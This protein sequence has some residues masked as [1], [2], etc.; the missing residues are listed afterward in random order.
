MSG[1]L[2]RSALDQLIESVADFRVV[3]VNGPRQAGKTTLLSMYQDRHQGQYRSLDDAEQ[4]SAALADPV[5]YVESQVRPL[6]IDEVQRGGDPLVLAIKRAV[7]TNP[8]PGQFVLAGSSSFL[9]V[10]TLSESLAGRTVFVD[11]WPLSVS[12][13]VQAATGFMDQ[14]FHRVSDLA[15][16]RSPWTKRDYLDVICT[17]GFPQ[18]VQVGSAASR[19]RWFT[20]YLRTVV[21]RDI[22][23]FAQPRHAQAIPRLAGMIAARHGGL[24]VVSDM[25]K[26]LGLDH[27]TVQQYISYLETVFLVTTVPAW[28][29]N[30]TSRFVKTPKAFLTDSGLAAHLLGVSPEALEE[31][32]HRLLGGMVEDFVYSELLKQQSLTGDA[33]TIHHYRDRDKREIDFICE[34][35]DGRIAAFE[36]KASASPKAE[37]ARHLVWL[38][39]LLGDQFCAGVVLHLGQ[40]SFAYDDR[41]ASLPISALWNH[42]TPPR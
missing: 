40:E 23:D 21:S 9:T 30:A 4:L 25:A 38:R 26:S 2:P 36:V 18:A 5:S 17:G 27:H 13:R 28:S 7:D 35:P 24:L 31:P 6:I 32:G 37:H 19:R 1:L 29:T 14:V 33:F 39:N 3:V 11:L 20:G 10:P 22:A 34:L 41:I 42:H 8:E 16:H 15:G 12:E